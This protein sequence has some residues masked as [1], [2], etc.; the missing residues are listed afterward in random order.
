M[1]S[2]ERQ[3]SYFL[4]NCSVVSRRGASFSFILR[5]REMRQ[6]ARQRRFF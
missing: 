1:L 6:A 5:E 4:T 3:L 2:H